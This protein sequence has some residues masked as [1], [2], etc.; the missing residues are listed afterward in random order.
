M[1]HQQLLILE[2]LLVL[3]LA[4]YQFLVDKLIL[5]TRQFKCLFVGSI[6]LFV[7]L[8]NLVGK[9]KSKV[10]FFVVRVVGD[11]GFCVL[12]GEAIAFQFDLGEGSIG[13]VDGDFVFR[14]PGLG[15][16]G[17]LNGFGIALDGFV[18]VVVLELIISFI[19]MAFTDAEI[20]LHL[21]LILSLRSIASSF[22]CINSPT[23]SCKFHRLEVAINQKYCSPLWGE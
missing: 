1:K 21:Q 5:L 6:R 13:V 4:V 15:F 23:P 19:L 11:A 22:P 18:V 12:N 20:V 9:G 3:L 7:V 2:V 8:Q 16:A 14:H 10:T 17:V